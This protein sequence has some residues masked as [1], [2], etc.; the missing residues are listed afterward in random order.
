MEV[1]KLFYLIGVALLGGRIV[2]S[3]IANNNSSRECLAFIWIKS[4]V[5][6]LGVTLLGY[7]LN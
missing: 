6:E 2:F 3:S 1:E 7:H 5:K 4:Y